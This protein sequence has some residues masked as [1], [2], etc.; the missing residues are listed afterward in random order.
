MQVSASQ[1]NGPIQKVRIKDKNQT[2][3]SI[4][5]DDYE[6]AMGL[7][8]E[9]ET[10][11]D[12]ESYND[13]DET[14]V[15]SGGTSSQTRGRSIRLRSGR[16][17]GSQ[18][19]IISSYVTR[20]SASNGHRVREDNVAQRQTRATRRQQQN[21]RECHA[22]SSQISSP[23][24]TASSHNSSLSINEHSSFQECSREDND[25]DEELPGTVI[26]SGRLVFLCLMV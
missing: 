21:G 23:T 2:N 9:E 11:S 26:S 13:P 12:D 14:F 17:S 6:V 16:T 1:P 7:L 15:P 22:F 24:S 20:N 5:D 19:T 18:T 3:I 25:W 8:S 4:A 10:Q